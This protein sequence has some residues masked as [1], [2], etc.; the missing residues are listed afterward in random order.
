LPTNIA[1]GY[2]DP[3]VE[4]KTEIWFSQIERWVSSDRATYHLKLHIESAYKQ[5][6][7]T[8]QGT[9]NMLAVTTVV[10]ASAGAFAM[11]L[12]IRRPRSTTQS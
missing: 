10:F 2:T 9:A 5:M 3:T 1:A 6:Y 8:T 12:F 7:E 11:L 4:A